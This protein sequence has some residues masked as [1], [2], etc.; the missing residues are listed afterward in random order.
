MYTVV[1][2]SGV[3]H[4][5][6]ADRGR[7]LCSLYCLQA[8]AESLSSLRRNSPNFRKQKGGVS[9]SLPHMRSN[10]YNYTV[11]NVQYA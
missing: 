7:T 9:G 6:P 5:L 8:T 4:R 3:T 2:D 10:K 1:E 11:L